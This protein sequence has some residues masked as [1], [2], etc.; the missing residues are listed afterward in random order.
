M[1]VRGSSAV[2]LTAMAILIFFA[3]SP[4]TAGSDANCDKYC[5]CCGTSCTTRPGCTES[6]YGT[7]LVKTCNNCVFACHNVLICGVQCDDNPFQCC[8]GLYLDVCG[9]QADCQYERC[10]CG[11]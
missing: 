11:P 3:S 2:T 7:C 10:P 8:G 6:G 1:L 5:G 4:P 9:T